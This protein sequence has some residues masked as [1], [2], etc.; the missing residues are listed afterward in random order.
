[1]FHKNV[2]TRQLRQLRKITQGN[3]HWFKTLG[4]EQQDSLHPSAYELTG[5]RN[6]IVRTLNQM[7]YEDH[8]I[9]HKRFREH[10][11]YAAIVKRDQELGSVI[12]DDP[13]EVRRRKRQEFCSAIQGYALFLLIRTYELLHYKETKGLKRRGARDR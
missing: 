3:L 5:K 4:T 13:Y 9:Y 11:Q 8:I 2:T 1:M 12:P 6:Y 7:M 10:P